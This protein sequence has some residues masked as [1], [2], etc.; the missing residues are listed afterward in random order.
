M[1]ELG[2]A[3]TKHYFSLEELL[4]IRYFAEFVGK[5]RHELSTNS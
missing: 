2:N 4:N 1:V 3:P 5:I